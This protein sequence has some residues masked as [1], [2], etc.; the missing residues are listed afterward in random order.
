MLGINE[1]LHGF[2][3]QICPPIGSSRSALSAHKRF[4]II[5]MNNDGHTTLHFYCGD[6][7]RLLIKF[8][9]TLIQRSVPRQNWPTCEFKEAIR[10]D[11]NAFFLAI[12]YAGRG[13]EW[14]EF[15]WPANP[16]NPVGPWILDTQ[17]ADP[18]DGICRL[19]PQP[20]EGQVVTLFGCAFR[21]QCIADESCAAKLIRLPTE[22]DEP[23]ALD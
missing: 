20:P 6:A 4:A 17:G 18:C 22:T 11:K 7:S 10:D 16:V 12:Q 13:A 5:S 19:Y 21:V 15:A 14:W 2:E 1:L 23:S 3:F 9:C 8:G